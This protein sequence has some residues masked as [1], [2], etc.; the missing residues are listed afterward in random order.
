MTAPNGRRP[1]KAKIY[2][3]TFGMSC[4]YH[5]HL[6]RQSRKHGRQPGTI[7]QDSRSR[8]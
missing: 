3:G 6:I 4:I 7:H 2:E 5:H 8:I 1:C